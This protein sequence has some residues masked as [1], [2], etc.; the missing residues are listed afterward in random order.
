[1]HV[2]Q[3]VAVL[4]GNIDQGLRDVIPLRLDTV[5]MDLIVTEPAPVTAKA[6]II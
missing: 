1:V 4:L 5:G 6:R 2:L 3:A